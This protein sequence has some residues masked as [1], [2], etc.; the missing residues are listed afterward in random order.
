MKKKTWLNNKF[1][2]FG[3]P[4]EVCSAPDDLFA[5]DVTRVLEEVAWAGR[6]RDQFGRGVTTEGTVSK[7]AEAERYDERRAKKKRQTK[8]MKRRLSTTSQWKQKR[9]QKEKKERE[10]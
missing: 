8:T 5:T 4:G 1:Q 6:E 3:R 2:V 9:C 7:K 10:R